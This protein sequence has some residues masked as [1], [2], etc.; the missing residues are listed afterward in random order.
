MTTLSTAAATI[1]ASAEPRQITLTVNGKVRRAVAEPRLLLS[2][3]IRQELRLAGTN[4][5]CEQGACGA[6]T[7]KLDGDLVRSCITLAVQ[8]DGAEVETVEG[9][10]VDGQLNPLQEA[11]HEEHGLQCGFCTPGMLMTAGA[12]LEKNS[13][14]TDAEIREHMSG[15]I[16]RCTGYQ[17]IIDSV[18]CAAKKLQAANAT[19]AQKDEVTR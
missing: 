7:V 8:A 10:A 9:L 2:D 14:P 5:G 18:R 19:D 17:G 16:C 4:I 13:E 6:C 3:F 12:L 15:N 11:F 1:T